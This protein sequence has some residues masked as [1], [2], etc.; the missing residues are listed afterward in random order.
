MLQT[1]KA[2]CFKEIVLQVPVDPQERQVS[3]QE[4]QHESQELRG[5]AE[6]VKRRVSY[7][8]RLMDDADSHLCE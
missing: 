5:M 2:P 1:M 6:A 8:T 3:A 7:N 4:E